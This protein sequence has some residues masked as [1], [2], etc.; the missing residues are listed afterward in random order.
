M[1]SRSYGK[2]TRGGKV[3]FVFEKIREK[4]LL[5]ITGQGLMA[6]EI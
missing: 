2:R 6:L 1:V 5:K 4:K 3:D